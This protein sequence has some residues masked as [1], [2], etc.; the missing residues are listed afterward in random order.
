MSRAQPA[1]ARQHAVQS[2]ASGGGGRACERTH[3][4]VAG[5]P[6]AASAE[7]QWWRHQPARHAICG[8]CPPRGDAEPTRRALPQGCSAAA[9]APCARGGFSSGRAAR[10][11]CGV[12]AL[13]QRRPLWRA[14]SLCLR[15]DR[16]PRRTLTNAHTSRPHHHLPRWRPRWCATR[17]AGP[18]C[19]NQASVKG[20]PSTVIKQLGWALSLEPYNAAL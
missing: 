4:R 7:R 3:L 19:D 10:G 1:R 17:A 16:A 6:H 14:R 18:R 8:A 11:A 2:R 12:K 5:R 13:R 20:Q 9:A 15:C